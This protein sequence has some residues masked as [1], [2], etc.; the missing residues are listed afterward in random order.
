[1]IVEKLTWPR[2]Y[3][4]VLS[5]HETTGI[6]ASKLFRCGRS[7]LVQRMRLRVW[8]LSGCIFRSTELQVSFMSLRAWE[9]SACHRTAESMW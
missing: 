1:M 8:I 6:A 5:W 7:S 3:S 9:E 2:S 4:E